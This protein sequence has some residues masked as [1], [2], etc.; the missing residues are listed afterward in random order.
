MPSSAH[1]EFQLS[2]FYTNA[3]F[4]ALEQDQITI[5][6]FE[7]IQLI[8][9]LRFYRIRD[10]HAKTLPWPVT[11]IVHRST[12]SIFA[13]AR[14][15]KRGFS[16][17]SKSNFF[18]SDGEFASRMRTNFWA[19][20]GWGWNAT[21]VAATSWG[22]RVAKAAEREKGPDLWKELRH[23]EGFFEGESRQDTSNTPFT[24]TEQAEI[25]ARIKKARDYART[26]G[27]LN[28]EQI[29]RIETRLDHIEEASTR[30]GRKDWLMMFNGGILSL[31]L[32]DTITPQ[33]AQHIFMLV[34]HGLGHFFGYG[35]P[36]PHLP[37]P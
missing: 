6:E 32:A 37:G 14:V 1:E 3:L 25:S 34:V 33:V 23:G 13:T 19:R 10:G 8:V 18:G 28:S 4:K 27:E 24:G 16:T 22:R 31:V 35:G 17:R 11:V 9:D 26:S 20:R 30:I 7:L 36:P 29:A 5:A 21:L 15:T 12:R 2:K